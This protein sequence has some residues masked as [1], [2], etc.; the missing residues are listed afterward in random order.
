[1]PTYKGN[2]GHLMQHWPL[3]EMLEVAARKGVTGLNYI[4]AHAMAPLATEN[5]GKDTKFQNAENR[6]PKLGDS[7]SAYEKAW[8]NLTSDHHPPK[9]YP[10]SAA[11][12]K[13]VWKGDF[14]MLLCE[15]DQPT[16]DAIKP[17]LQRVDKLER[18]KATELFRRDWRERFKK[19]SPRPADVRLADNSLTLVLFDPN[20]CGHKDVVGNRW[21]N[22]YPKDIQL[23]VHGMTGLR[24]GILIQLPTYT[25]NGGNRQVDVIASMNLGLE[26]KGF[27]LIGIVRIDGHMMSLVYARNV[28]WAAELADLPGRFDNWFS[29]I[30]PSK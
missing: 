30:Q 4:D 28:P 20:M 7:A 15:R 19:G 17:W 5:P 8:Y 9:G 12:V 26:P 29:A 14:S 11:F 10:N 24:G 2:A 13:Q 25:A 3:C 23:A 1:M 27:K 6:L 22:V 21:W 18:C 16:I